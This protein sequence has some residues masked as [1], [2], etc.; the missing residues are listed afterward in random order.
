MDG[1]AVHPELEQFTTEAEAAGR[2]HDVSGVVQADVALLKQAEA[3]M[4]AFMASFEDAAA[5]PPC[6]PLTAAVADGFVEHRSSLTI[7]TSG[8]PN[9]PRTLACARKPENEYPSGRQ[10]C[11]LPD[12]AMLHHAGFRRPSKPHKAHTHACF[13]CTTPQ[14]HPLDLLKTRKRFLDPWNALIRRT[15]GLLVNLQ[16]VP[17]LC[18]K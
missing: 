14:I 9:T 6:V 17:E 8:S 1:I 16:S 7:R 5:V 10:C 2:H 12:C 3:E 4:A 15:T 13:R 18:E 11:R